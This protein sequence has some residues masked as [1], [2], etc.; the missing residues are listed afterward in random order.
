[1]HHI[2]DAAFSAGNMNGCLRGTRIDVLLQ[3]EQW[4]MYE[5][6][7]TVFWMNGPAGTGKSTIART[8]AE[9]SFFDGRLGASFFCARDFR[10]RSN[11]Q[12]IFPTLAFQLAQRHPQFREQLLKIL[13][14]DPDAG[15][16]SLSSQLDNLIV[17][18]FKATQISTLII[19]DA[20]DECKDKEPTSTL[21]SVLSR[22]VHEIPNVKIFITSRAEPPIQEGFRL[23]LLRPITD[24]LRLHEVDRSSVDEDIRVYLRTRLTKI[25]RRKGRKIPEV[26][27]TPHEFDRLCEKAAGLFICASKLVKF[28]A[29]KYHLP[30]ERLDLILHSRG[31]TRETWI[32]HTYAQTLKLA[33]QDLDPDEQEFYSH[34]RIIIG[35]VSVAFHP[36][37]TKALSDL[38]TK[39]GTPSQIRTTLRL[40]HSLLDVP[41]NEDDPIRVFHPSFVHFISDRTRCKDKRFLTDASVQHRDILFSCFDLM[42]ERLKKN[43]CGLDDYA[44]LG[45]VRDLSSR[46]ETYIGKS[47]EYAC[48]FWTRHLASIPGNG[49]HVERLQEAIDVLF[50]GNLLYWIEVLSILGCLEVAVYAIDDIRQWYISVSCTAGLKQTTSSYTPIR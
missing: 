3:I 40:L 27:P 2:A 44:V 38:I 6:K 49:P 43:I 45:E 13:R 22:C 20:L 32:D 42:K 23:E 25:K 1:M 47:L 5:K 17:R 12:V 30:N 4:L 7:K 21:L 34:C 48:R 46:R 36:L 41:D 14:A 8:F 11:L 31:A 19:I 26:W 29:S 33:F 37:S 50:T 16:G 10:D 24:V 15:R 9:I 28:I 35:A 39:C 18:P